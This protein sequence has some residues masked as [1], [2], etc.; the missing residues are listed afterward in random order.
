MREGGGRSKKKIHVN[1]RLRQKTKTADE[2]ARDTEKSSRE[3]YE[4][5]SVGEKDP[6]RSDEHY[7]HRGE[8][9]GVKALSPSSQVSLTGAEQGGFPSAAAPHRGHSRARRRAPSP[10]RY[11]RLPT[12]GRERDISR[13]GRPG[14][15]GVSLL[16][17]C[18]FFSFN[19]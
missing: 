6:I 9:R 2:K 8:G 3:G 15:L 12:T 10:P 1:S 18:L 14:P 4:D 13:E 5:I 19:I 16:V 17:I 11:R 7:A